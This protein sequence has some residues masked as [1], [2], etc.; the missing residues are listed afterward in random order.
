MT[1][2]YTVTDD[3]KVIIKS[4]T[5]KI[6]EVG[7]FESEESANYWGTNVCAKYNAP[8]YKDIEYPNQLPD[9]GL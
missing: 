4:G 9:L 6:D 5:K 2:S 1:L 3:F 8:E 7:A